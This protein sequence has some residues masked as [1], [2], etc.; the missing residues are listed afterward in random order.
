MKRDM[1]LVRRILIALESDEITEDQRYSGNWFEDVDEYVFYYHVKIMRQANLVECS[2][3]PQGDGLPDKY[4]PFEITWDGHEFLDAVRNENIWSS[5][6]DKLGKELAT[7]PMGALMAVS[8]EAA[9]AWALEK[10]GLRAP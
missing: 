6:K 4:L 7:L 9:K 1:E 10:L 8:L 3:I 5:L 2:I